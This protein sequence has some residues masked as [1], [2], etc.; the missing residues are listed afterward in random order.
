MTTIQASAFFENCRTW[1]AVRFGK[2][3][4][5]PDPLWKVKAK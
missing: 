2:V 3:V 4:L 5:D 1:L